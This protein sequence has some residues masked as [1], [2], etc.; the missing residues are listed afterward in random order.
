MINKVS[1]SA[2]FSSR[3]SESDS[4]IQIAAIKTMIQFID[5]SFSITYTNTQRRDGSQFRLHESSH[6]ETITFLL[7]SIA[8]I[9]KIEDICSDTN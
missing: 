4:G 3:F 5:G 8:D 9:Y 6:C 1:G 7:F 2:P